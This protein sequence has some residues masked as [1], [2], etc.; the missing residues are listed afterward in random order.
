M[1]TDFGT[2]RDRE[3]VA[4]Q[5]IDDGGLSNVIDA[6]A[7]VCWAKGEHLRSA[8]QDEQSAHA[9]ER[10]AGKLDLLAADAQDLQGA[11]YL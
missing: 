6:L 5:M 8:W 3:I 4:E 1:T 9:W 11:D 2:T 7:K 10:M